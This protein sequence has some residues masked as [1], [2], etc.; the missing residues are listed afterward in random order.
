MDKL[1]VCKI[2]IVLKSVINRFDKL[3]ANVDHLENSLRHCVSNT[4]R[5]TTSPS[6]CLRV[7]LQYDKPFTHTQYVQA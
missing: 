3:I 5:S 1:I 4:S 7:Q 6:Q 2:V